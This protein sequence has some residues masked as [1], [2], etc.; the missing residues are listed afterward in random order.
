MKLPKWVEI[1]IAVKPLVL[2]LNSI[3][4]VY[5]NSSCGGHKVQHVC[6]QMPEGYFYVDC[7]IENKKVIA[8]LRGFAKINRGFKITRWNEGPGTG[9]RYDLKGTHQ[10]MKLLEKVLLREKF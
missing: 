3:P 8:F 10:N 7:D 5:T 9:W 6:S 2:I 4:G 1:D